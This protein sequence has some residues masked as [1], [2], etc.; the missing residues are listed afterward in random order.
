[1]AKDLK[2]KALH[3]DPDALLGV[4]ALVALAL[5]PEGTFARIVEN[6]SLFGALAAIVLGGRYGVR[7]V[8][9]H[10]EGKVIVE[11]GPEAALVAAGVELTD[12]D[13]DEL[14]AAR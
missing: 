6:A 4:A 5:A 13:L 14:D 8:G 3:R 11:H 7:M 9:A 1:M 12:D 10:G 2:I